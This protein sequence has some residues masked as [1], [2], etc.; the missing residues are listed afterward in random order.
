MFEGH[1][2]VRDA[3]F[4]LSFGQPTT[5]LLVERISSC[6]IHYPSHSTSHTLVRI[7]NEETRIQNGFTLQSACW[8][9]FCFSYRGIPSSTRKKV[10]R[11][12]PEAQQTVTT[13]P[14]ITS[15]LGCLGSEPD[16]D[17][18]DNDQDDVELFL[19][20]DH[21]IDTSDMDDD[22]EVTIK[23]PRG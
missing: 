14:S 21:D 15:V 20:T 1:N 5:S 19:D 8:V 23:T 7:T 3:E 22:L 4:Q 10:K 13:A 9:V 12:I 18:I 6:T 16:I 2:D 17:D 11:K